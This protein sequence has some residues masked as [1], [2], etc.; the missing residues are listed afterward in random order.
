MT[1]QVSIPRGEIDYLATVA[2]V[3]PRRIGALGICAGGGNAVHTARTDHRIRAIAIDDVDQ[4]IQRLTPFFAD[5]L[6]T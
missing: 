3:D 5:H 4:A 2:G 1:R 6:V